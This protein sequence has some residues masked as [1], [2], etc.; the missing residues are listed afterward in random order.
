MTHTCPHWRYKKLE[1]TGEVK[2]IKDVTLY[3]KA[4]E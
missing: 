4:E 3:G 1:F 2:A